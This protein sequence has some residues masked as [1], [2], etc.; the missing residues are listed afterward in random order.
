[1]SR[2]DYPLIALLAAS[3]FAL[4]LADCAGPGH[5]RSDEHANIYPENYKSELVG[6]LHSYINDPTQIR[7]AA[8][9]DPVVR[10]VSNAAQDHRCG[11]SDRGR[12]SA[13][14]VGDVFNPGGGPRERY[15]V[16]VRYNAKDRDGRYARDGSLCRRPFRSLHG[17]IARGV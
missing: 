2:A 15:V 5:T 13:D 11:P 12:G 16:C 7:D 4:A 9:A 14:R 1:M 3:V 17:A 10:P 8:I 6:F